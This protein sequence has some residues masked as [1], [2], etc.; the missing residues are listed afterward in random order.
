[1]F[2]YFCSIGIHPVLMRGA[3]RRCCA[4]TL[5]PPRPSHPD[6]CARASGA[7]GAPSRSSGSP[8]RNP[9]RNRALDR[10]AACP[11]GAAPARMA[12]FPHSRRRRA[13]CGQRAEN[14]GLREKPVPLAFPPEDCWRVLFSPAAERSHGGARAR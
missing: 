6:T 4:L 8:L 10:A 7:G 5:H 1:M 2:A 9:R 14:H 13:H 11:A 12:S 3:R